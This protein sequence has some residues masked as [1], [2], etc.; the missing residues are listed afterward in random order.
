MWTHLHS[1]F[2]NLYYTLMQIVKIV[3]YHTQIWVQKEKFIFLKM[4]VAGIELFGG[5]LLSCLKFIPSCNQNLT[6]NGKAGDEHSG[7]VVVMTCHGFRDI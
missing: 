5:K 2:T 3:F 6:W 7:V 1:V 4:Q